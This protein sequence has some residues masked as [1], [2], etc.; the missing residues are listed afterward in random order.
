MQA[1]KP[2]DLDD[3]AREALSV[4]QKDCQDEKTAAAMLTGLV[5]MSRG[6]VQAAHLADA[7]IN[8][9][10][11]NLTQIGMMDLKAF[12]ETCAILISN[13][14]LY[15][16]NNNINEGILSTAIRKI[17]AVQKHIYS[18][19]VVELPDHVK[20][21]KT[22]A[23]LQK[24]VDRA[25][26]N[27]Q[28]CV[29]RY[30]TA[31]EEHRVLAKNNKW[32]KQ[33]LSQDKQS[34]IA[35]EAAFSQIHLLTSTLDLN[36]VEPFP[37]IRLPHSLF[38]VRGESGL[39][40]F[41]QLH[42]PNMNPNLRTLLIE[43]PRTALAITTWCGSADLALSLMANEG[44]GNKHLL[45]GLEKVMKKESIENARES[46]D[47]LKKHLESCSKNSSLEKSRRSQAS[48]VLKNI[49]SLEKSL[50]K[51]AAKKHQSGRTL[52]SSRA[53]KWKG[54][55][56]NISWPSLQSILHRRTNPASANTQYKN[57]KK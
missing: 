6:E 9:I 8:R 20:E 47:S 37:S 42:Q 11:H 26:E 10:L 36:H 31:Q 45:K 57:R 29:E 39:N 40:L 54:F 19:I 53:K 34:K 38:E 35:F 1:R 41:N 16:M 12:D 43:D 13:L 28:E 30:V 51:E 56:I 24:M 25:C 18:H 44:G 49:Q 22:T 14:R 27:I 55:S 21:D 32:Y 33:H 2:G 17:E 15:A 46:L 50:K 48:K 52:E 7:N 5:V 4:Y 23:S 3:V